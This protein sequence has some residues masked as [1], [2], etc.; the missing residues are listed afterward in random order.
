M[1]TTEENCFSVYMHVFPN[2]KRYFGLTSKDPEARWK[3]GLGYAGQFPMFHDIIKYGWA[4]VTHIVL[5][6]ALSRADAE[7]AEILLI[8]NNRATDSR[9]GYN[10]SL[11]GGHPCQPSEATRAKMRANRLGKRVSAE[12]R[13][14]MRDAKLGKKATP[15]A[16][17]KMSASRKGRPL[18][19]HIRR[20]LMG[21]SNGNK[22]VVQL[23]PDG[24]VLRTFQSVKAAYSG[25]GRSVSWVIRD[26]CNQAI[27]D[28]G[29]KRTFHGTLWRWAPA[30][31]GV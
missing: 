25:L 9:F 26:I 1:S 2:G 31:R 19:Q 16:R 20:S 12:T 13:K 14:K 24:R 18:P 6:T 8:A 21:N 15:E 27:L 4:N 29:L 11:G 3:G 7:K 5:L 23:S 22:A 17:A 10:K 30:K 28:P